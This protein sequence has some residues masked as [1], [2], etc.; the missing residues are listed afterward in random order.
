M[1]RFITR[2]RRRPENFEQFCSRNWLVPDHVASKRLHDS[3]EVQSA[4][5]PKLRTRCSR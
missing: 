4:K 2:Q 3:R 5:G 1:S